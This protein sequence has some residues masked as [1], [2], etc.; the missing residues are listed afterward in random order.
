MAFLLMVF[1]SLIPLT[2][3]VILFRLKYQRVTY[4]LAVFY[5]AVSMWQMSIA[6]LYGEEW[7]DQKTIESLFRFF[8]MGTV[9]FAPLLFYMVYQLLFF[10]ELQFDVRKKKILQKL[11]NRFSYIGMLIWTIVVYM[12]SWTPLG[13]A[14][15]DRHSIP[16]F[17]EE[18]YYP[19]AG[20]LGWTFSIHILLIIVM[21]LLAIYLT[22]KIVDKHRRTFLRVFFVSLLL[23]YSFGVINLSSD[24]PLFQAIL[25][26]IILVMG[27][28]TAYVK[29]IYNKM[30]EVNG[31]LLIQ[32]LFLRRVIDANPNFIYAKDQYG[33]FTMANAAIAALYGVS[34]EQMLGKRE[35]DFYA[36]PKQA[37]EM[38]KEDMYLLEKDEAKIQEKQYLQTP[39]DRMYTVQITKK[40]LFFSA[41]HKELLCVA[42]DITEMEQK[43]EYIRKT[44]KLNIVGQ[45]AAGVAHEI[46]NPLTSLK[47][48]IQLIDQ[49]YSIDPKYTK[50]ML[51]EL[52]RIEFVS[53]EMLVLAKPEVIVK[54]S[55][56]LS[57]LMRDV[58]DLLN[59][60]AITQSIN[61]QM[62][63]FK[64]E[65]ELEGN[66]NQLKQVFINVLKNAVEASPKNSIIA[67]DHEQIHNRLAVSITDRGM[68]MPKE[69]LE[70]LGE[71]FYTSKEKGT[72]LGLMVSMRIIK[73]HGG[74]MTFQSRE[75]EGTKV[76]VWLP[77]K[78]GEKK[79]K[80]AGA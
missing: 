43:E 53:S 50:I 34:S 66:T 36:D 17:N 14:G 23:A 62:E 8:R 77:I 70:K 64:E 20:P 7:L 2:T 29:L 9:V 26:L 12:I 16:P 80:S 51:D 65:V 28:F 40:P 57:H 69:R 67:I 44:E 33:R 73:E 4:P 55:I 10:E 6:V 35:S 30:E 71:P 54:Q 31:Q 22:F 11:I 25:A 52:E 49:E 78:A 13:I 79:E 32:Q 56:T 41:G 72:G 46:R 19:M 76:T 48:F 27:I 75:G 3:F 1:F 15:F 5:L 61:I 21:D 24:S 38:A 68:G 39:D 45:L 63:P 74:D 59:M 47:G 60:Q 42:T 37:E 58:V 18:F